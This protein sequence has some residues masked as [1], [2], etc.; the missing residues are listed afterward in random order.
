MMK[1]KKNKSNRMKD[2]NILMILNK[3]VRLGKL[4]KNLR[5]K[6][7]IIRTIIVRVM[8]INWILVSIALDTD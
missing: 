8:R 3:V 6:W 2:R 1:L 7:R 4:K 5:R